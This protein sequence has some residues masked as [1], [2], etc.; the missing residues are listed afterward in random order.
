MHIALYKC[1]IILYC[2]DH[3]YRKHIVPPPAR[4]L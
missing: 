4:K 2:S 3:K 1:I